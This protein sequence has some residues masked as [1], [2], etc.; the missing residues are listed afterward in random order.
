MVVHVIHF[1]LFF[2]FT[3]LR[4]ASLTR[5]S[6]FACRTPNTCDGVVVVVARVSCGVTTVMGAEAIGAP[7][8]MALVRA[9]QCKIISC[10]T[11]VFVLYVIT[12]VMCAES[13]RCTICNGAGA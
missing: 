8:A 9:K 4:I 5:R 10:D 12:T 6:T 11:V 3:E 13:N 7:F 1:F 2:L